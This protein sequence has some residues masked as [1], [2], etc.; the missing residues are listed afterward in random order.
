M[1]AENGHPGVVYDALGGE[2]LTLGRARPRSRQVRTRGRAA[3]R[4][5]PAHA[6]RSSRDE[7]GGRL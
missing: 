2:M 1:L 3:E 4:A 6:S 7:L 5:P